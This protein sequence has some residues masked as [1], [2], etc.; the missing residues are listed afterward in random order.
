L[1]VAARGAETPA[2]IGGKEPP[3]AARSVHLGW[4]APE[5][6]LFYLEMTVEQ[7]T[8]GSYFMGCGWNTGYFGIQELG[9][10][11]KVAIFSVWDPAKGDDP[12]A[13]KPEDRVELLHQGEGVRI[14]RF[15]GEGTGGQCMMDFPWS[16]GRT[17]RLVVRAEVEANKTAYAG[18]LFMPEKNAWK[19]LVTFRT[20]T[21]GTRLKG[22]YSF[23]EDFRRDGGSVLDTRRAR[24]GN[25]WVK[26]ARGEY[27]PLD[28]ARF[29]ASGAE[30]EARDNINA[31]MIGGEFFLAT[32]GD[33]RQ[34]Q[35]LRSVME[36]PAGNLSIPAE[37]KR[38]LDGLGNSPA[39]GKY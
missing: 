5:C 31:G 34:T 35:A 17:N 8:A 33:L 32:G 19:H 11:R 2:S 1:A 7:S 29:T 25:G 24:F 18:Y 22:L 30:W 6:E 13:V 23:V 26:T 15:G 3:R 37:L 36:R 10:D 14:R 28:K 9:P 4:T 20:R 12:K 27:V 38:E 16:I 39:A 21:G